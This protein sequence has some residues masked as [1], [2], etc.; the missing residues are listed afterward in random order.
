MIVASGRSHRHVG[1]MADHLL[2]TLK[3]AGY[4]RAR[5]EGLPHCDWVLIDAGDVIVHIF[6][7]RCG[8]ST[9][10]RRSGPST[11]LT[12]C[13]ARPRSRKMSAALKLMDAEEF[14]SWAEGREGT[15]ELVDGVA[16]L[17]RMGQ[18]AELM[19]GTSVRHD[20]V[21]R[22]IEF[23][24]FARLRGG[25]CEVF[26]EAVATRVS[27]TRIRRPDISVDCGNPASSA[28][29]TA[30]P[31][32]LFEIISPSSRRID[33]HEKPAEYRSLPSL[34]HFVIVEPG[35]PVCTVWSRRDGG[36][37][38]DRPVIGLDSFL[39]LTAIGVVLPFL[40]IYDGVELEE[41][42]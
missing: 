14:L 3:D 15:W 33:F 39:D 25:P 31:T 6:R 27:S 42:A 8:S 36:G 16:R 19:S 28:L 18:P 4:G 5:V 9:T 20:R 34:R 7:P 21:R 12:A 38:E 2:R 10:S 13:R 32:V 37:W 17:K 41:R 26:S 23:A 35:A 40:E 29:E 1:A 30:E 11:P 24:L 22:N